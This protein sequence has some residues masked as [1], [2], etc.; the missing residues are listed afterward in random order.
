MIGMWSE[1]SGVRLGVAADAVQR[2]DERLGR[3][4]GLDAAGPDSAGVDIVLLEGNASQIGPD[5]RKV[6]RSGS[7]ISVSLVGFQANS[8]V[9][10]GVDGSGC[11]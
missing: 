5:A 7:L 3:V 1:V 9:S 8:G 10:P 6:C 4:T 2:Q 11:F